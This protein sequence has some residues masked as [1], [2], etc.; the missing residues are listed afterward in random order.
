MPADALAL[1]EASLTRTERK[2]VNRLKTP[3]QIQAYL[4]D[5]PYR[6]EDRYCCPL[7][8]LRDQRA[9]CFDGALFAAA[10]LRRLGYPPLLVDLSAERDD[11]H[12]L[13]IYKNDGH[14]GA[15]AKSNF[16][17]LRYREPIYRS[18]RELVMSYF[19]DYY[20]L[21]GMKSLRRYSLP[22]NLKAF[23]RF[24]WMTSDEH[25]DKIAERLNAIHHIPLLT[26]QMVARLSPLDKRSYEAGMLGTDMAGVYQPE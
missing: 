15:L 21:E 16:V 2:V 18:L 13:A 19:E 5:L 8:V 11:D 17:G 10:M 1:F 24:H 4:D 6:T 12:I 7:T 20:N 26:P 9:H 22:L 14:Y 25:L 23:D 3:A